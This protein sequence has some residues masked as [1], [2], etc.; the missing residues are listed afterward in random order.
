MSHVFVICSP[1]YKQAMC[2]IAATVSLPLF[3]DTIEGSSRETVDF[4][5]VWGDGQQSL[6][7]NLTDSY[8]V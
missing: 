7:L 5:C 4:I 8:L 6:H 3:T 1:Q 2:L